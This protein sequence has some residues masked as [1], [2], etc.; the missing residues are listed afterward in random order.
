[1]IGDW[2][3]HKITFTFIDIINATKYA[4]STQLHLPTSSQS[5][6]PAQQTPLEPPKMGKHPK[7][8]AWLVLGIAVGIG[9]LV[10]A[11]VAIAFLCTKQRNPIEKR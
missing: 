5:V 11:I 9:T 1:M 6:S 2:E 7:M 8:I 3:K 4:D 10:F